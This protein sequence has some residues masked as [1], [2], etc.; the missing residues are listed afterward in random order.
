MVDLLGQP[1]ANPAQRA[2]EKRLHHRPQHR[3]AEE[4]GSIVGI[5]VLE[6]TGQGQR[7]SQ[8]FRLAWDVHQQQA[9]PQDNGTDG[10]GNDAGSAQGRDGGQQNGKDHC[11]KDLA[12]QRQKDIL[13]HG[14]GIGKQPELLQS[15]YRLIEPQ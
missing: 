12:G 15:G 14:H 13:P 5:K 3:E 4:V 11:R 8:P 10:L 7:A 1:H 2:P 6:R 9:S